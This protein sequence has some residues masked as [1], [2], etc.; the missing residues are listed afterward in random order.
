MAWEDLAGDSPDHPHLDPPQEGQE[1]EE[2]EGQDGPGQDGPGHS[3]AEHVEQAEGEVGLDT[4]GGHGVGVVDY[5]DGLDHDGAQQVGTAE[6]YQNLERS[7]YSFYV[8]KPN[9]SYS[10]HIS[11]LSAHEVSMTYDFNSGNTFSPK[12]ES[13]NSYHVSSIQLLLHK[14]DEMS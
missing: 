13:V 8:N 6:I 3:P 7:S 12:K 11:Y 5:R 10:A 9:T 14:Y 4:V 1:G 2:G